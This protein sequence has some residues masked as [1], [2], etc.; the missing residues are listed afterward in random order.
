MLR[1]LGSSGCS[2]SHG[3]PAAARMKELATSAVRA[4][5]SFAR[6]AEAST[7]GSV[8]PPSLR[9]AS[10]APERDPAAAMAPLGPGGGRAPDPGRRGKGGRPAERARMGAGRERGEGEGEGGRPR[11]AAMA[12]PCSSAERKAPRPWR[13]ST[14]RPRG[15]PPPR[16]GS[17]EGPWIPASSLQLGA[18]EGEGRWRGV[19]RRG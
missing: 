8:A 15:P 2:H 7:R 14:A 13:A 1:E 6:R 10:A 12:G 17:G 18:R 4:G 9:R 3:Y 19:G 11:A 16:H 5:P